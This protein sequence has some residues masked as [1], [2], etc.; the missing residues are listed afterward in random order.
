MRKLFIL[1]FAL[2]CFSGFNPILAENSTTIIEKPIYKE[3][4]VV[5]TNAVFINEV[6]QGNKK[7]AKSRMEKNEA[8]IGSCLVLLGFFIIAILIFFTERTIKRN[9]DR[10]LS[11]DEGGQ[12]ISLQ[13]TK[14]TIESLYKL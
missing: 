1:I 9:N 13:N 5:V 2:S 14:I 8:I 12:N 3:R 6:L 10:Y 4:L 7:I 11:S